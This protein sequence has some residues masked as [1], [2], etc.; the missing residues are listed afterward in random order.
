M[1]GRN[2]IT[3]RCDCHLS[4]E[5]TFE[6]VGVG[7]KHIKYLLSTYLLYSK[8]KIYLIY[9][10]LIDTRSIYSN[11]NNQGVRFNACLLTIIDNYWIY[12]DQFLPCFLPYPR[13]RTS[14]F[15]RYLLCAYSRYTMSVRMK[16]ICI[17]HP[18]QLCSLALSNRQDTRVLYNSIMRFIVV[19]IVSQCRYVGTYF[20]LA[21][22]RKL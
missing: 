22:A 17:C 5:L 21:F 6:A 2:E 8:Q 11:S 3:F 9:Y 15:I 12:F 4:N 1:R 20:R 19:L 14:F 16:A 18:D 10:I 13:R 7:V